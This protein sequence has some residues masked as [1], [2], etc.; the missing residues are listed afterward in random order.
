M[1]VAE[2]K[3][4]AGETRLNIAG[5]GSAQSP[6]AARARVPMP[7]A[8]NSSRASK[9]ESRLVVILVLGGSSVGGEEERI[10]NERK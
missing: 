5:R 2:I 6:L 7:A 10:R 8:I 9:T 3:T 4:T 1:E